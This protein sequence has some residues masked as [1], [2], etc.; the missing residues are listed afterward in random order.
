MNI[1]LFASSLPREGTCTEINTSMR[2]GACRIVSL[3]RLA[4]HFSFFSFPEL[5]KTKI[6]GEKSK[7]WS[8]RGL[9]CCDN[10]PVSLAVGE[11]E[12]G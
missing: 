1:V 2:G 10:Q 5:Q 4:K 6:K 3:F 11:V 9:R 8:R 7:Y 12:N